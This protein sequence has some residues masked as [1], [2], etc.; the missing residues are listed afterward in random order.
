[1]KILKKILLALVVILVLFQLVPRPEKNISDSASANDIS[2]V[3]NVPADVQQ[4]LK[5]SCNDCHSNNTVYPWY[6]KIQPVAMW[7]GN[8]VNEGKRELNFS[9]FAKYRLAKQYHKLEEINE[10]VKEDEM[11]LSSYTIVHT[12]AK[13]SQE[14]KLVL[15]N[16]TVAAMDAMKAKYPADSLIMKKRN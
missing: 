1:M 14:Q 8:H 2:T 3:H 16:W 15:A 4:I 10:Q 11:P 9:E 6:S 12:D 7:L 13:L 5:T